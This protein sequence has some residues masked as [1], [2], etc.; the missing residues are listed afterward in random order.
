[1]GRLSIVLIERRAMPR[2]SLAAWFQ[3]NCQEVRLATHPDPA[4]LCRRARPIRDVDIVVF[5]I[6]CA[7]VTDG[8]VLQTIERLRHVLAELPLVLMSDRE[9][10]EEVVEAIR[11]GARGFIPTSLDL[12]DAVEAL[13][14][15]VAGGTFVPAQSLMR[16]AENRQTASEEGAP[17]AD[18]EPFGRLTPRELEVLAR[19][20]Q[21]KP[22]KV[23]AHEL[24]ISESTVKVFVRRI[25]MKLRALNRT[26]VVYLT[27]RQF[28]E[29]EADL[30]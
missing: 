6:G 25:L 27:H 22:N 18:R 14:F 21:G 29:A 20:R 3:H 13:R 28:D 8:E 1:M 5:S 16:F 4:E 11:R 26:E 17:D 30:A 10:M 2:Q 15:V 7:A 23:I 19:L 9:E 24:E 12:D